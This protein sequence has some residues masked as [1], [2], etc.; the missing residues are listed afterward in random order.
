MWYNQEGLECG[1]T[2][3]G[4]VVEGSQIQTTRFQG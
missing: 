1:C 3:G 4:G 2:A